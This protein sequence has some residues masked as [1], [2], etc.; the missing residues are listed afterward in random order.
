[1]IDTD[2]IFAMS[3]LKW[4]WEILEGD[5]WTKLEADSVR[6][7]LDY[8]HEGGRWQAKWKNGALELSM[9]AP[10][11]TA[12]RLLLHCEGMSAPLHLIPCNIVG[13]NNIA[14]AKPGEFPLLT[15]DHPEIP[16]CASLWEF[17][18]DRAAMPVTFLYSGDTVLALSVDPYAETDRGPIPCGLIA[19][20]PNGIG[21]SLGYTNR[22]CTFL[23]RSTPAPTAFGRA[24]R[25]KTVCRLYAGQNS[26]TSIHEIIRREYAIRHERASYTRTIQEAA[27][28]VFD[29]LVKLNWDAASGEY[30][31]RHCRPPKETAL[32]P[33]RAV[34]EIGWTGG[35]ILALPM[36]RYSV[37][38]PD[39]DPSM[40]HGARDA[41]SF[42]DR[43]CQ[44]YNPA[45]GLLN[46]LMVP[47]GEGSRLNGWW[48]YY[49][50]VRDCHCAYT[51]GTAVFSLL[52]AVLFLR[53]HGLESPGRWLETAG[54]VLDTA[55]LLQR[56]DGAFGYTYSAERREVLDWE[57]FAGC[58]FVP[59]C[60]LYFRL[61]GESRFLLSAQK[62][63]A[64]YADFVKSLRCSGAPMDT[65]KSVDQEGNIAFVKGCRALYGI[66]GDR[67][68]LRWM[69]LG[70]GY[71]YLWRYGYRTRPEHAPLD[72]GW[73]ACGGSVTSVSN[74][75]IHPMGVLLDTDLRYL[76][77]AT[78]DRYH[79]SRALDSTAWL[80]QTL[81]LYPEKTGYG[82]Y[83]V[84][85]ERWCPSDGLLTEKNSDGLPYASWYSYNLWAAA[86]A[87]T[88][89]CDLLEESPSLDQPCP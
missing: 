66:T 68:C 58:W 69:E 37:L 52:Q 10:F 85:S 74:P 56:K 75:H 15:R 18:A 79:L 34:T 7:G 70:A 49:G 71:E 48:T 44:C 3:G 20:D 8:A 40:W 60:A 46:D 32:I 43:I 45:S 31:N 24:C 50:L 53:E 54:K 23:N 61:T 51:V 83:G 30:T 87:L 63:L 84:L 77:E 4:T 21:I 81:E 33:W 19:D 65:W 13:D 88:A 86:D 80:M 26:H 17:R 38:R 73:C 14:S 67:D 59:C 76:A 25:G 11:Q 62:G 57:G 78:G 12:M 41:R 29:A 72:E 89:L 28:A 1:M 9:D 6:E 42:F 82:V 64:Y 16:F 2:L 35:G 47:N 55:V 39:F 27:D 22:P 5:R 36:L